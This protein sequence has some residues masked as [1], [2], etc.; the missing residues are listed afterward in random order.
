METVNGRPEWAGM[1]AQDV[2]PGKWEIDVSPV[3]TTQAHPH[4][5]EAVA[6]RRPNEAT[7]LDKA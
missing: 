3:G 6:V 2:S 5:L 7:S 1:L 4:T